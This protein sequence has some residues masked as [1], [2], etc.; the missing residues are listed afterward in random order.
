MVSPAEVDEEPP[1][2]SELMQELLS[3]QKWCD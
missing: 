1:E 3:G 2:P